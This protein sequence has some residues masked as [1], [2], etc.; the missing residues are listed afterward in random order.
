ML[1]R[2]IEQYLETHK[3]LVVPQL[4]AF[5]VKEEP[6]TV[7]FSELLRRD[8]GVLQGLLVAEGM[9]ELAARG[10]IDRLVYEVRHAVE[11]G[12][13]Y[14]L[15]SFGEFYAGRQ[16]TILFE[17]HPRLSVVPEAPVDIIPDLIEKVRP[18]S[19]HV[20]PKRA[21]VV[22]ARP[23]EPK[24]VDVVAARPIEPKQS[25]WAEVED[26]EPTVEDE[27]IV[28]EEV[29]QV[30]EEELLDEVE[31]PKAPTVRPKTRPASAKRRP[32]PRGQQKPDRFLWVAIAAAVI[33]LL[34][35]GFGLY[36]DAVSGEEYEEPTELIEPLIETAAQSDPYGEMNE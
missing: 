26:D 23:I 36:N 4:G 30:S 14:Y 2:I 3:R 33:A 20:E 31:E 22:E 1:I 25:V 10:E 6:R 27:E 32:A 11:Q 21:D 8:D 18:E 5:L 24:R 35:I 19:R 17:Y 15:S 28:E 34:A 29:V 12:E 13:R 7:V 9:S 16:G